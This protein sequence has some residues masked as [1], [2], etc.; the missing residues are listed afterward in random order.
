MEHRRDSPAGRS[1][2]PGDGIGTLLVRTA[3]GDESAFTELYDAVAARVYGLC[4]RLVRD[5]AQA[6]EVSQEVLLEVWRTA[7]RYRPEHGS[8]LV[9]VLTVTHRRAVDRVRSAQA[10][11]DREH[12]AGTAAGGDTVDDVVD[13][14]TARLEYQQVRRCLR[15][16][17]ALQRQAIELAYY[18]GRT[19]REVAET[20]DVALPTVKSRMRDALIRLRDCLE[21]SRR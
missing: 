17:T 18:G 9:F 15:T 12:R 3:R 10:R 14:V 4:L 19:Y 11:R 16:L 8:G 2:G 5:P 7:A 1:P 20:L 13:T 6:E 21:V